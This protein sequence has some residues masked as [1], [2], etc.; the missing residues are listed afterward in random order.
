MREEV[1]ILKYTETEG[2]VSLRAMP[3]STKGQSE[4]RG[5]RRK[6]WAEPL[7]WLLREE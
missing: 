3:G 6:T 5:S 4:C 2:R 7:S 1:F